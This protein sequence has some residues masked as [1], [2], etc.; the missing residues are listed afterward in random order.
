MNRPYFY[1]IKHRKTGRY[2]VGS[3]YGKN[4]SPE[5]LFTTYFTSSKKIHYLINTEGLDS[6]EIVTLKER[7]DAREY[8]ARYLA[9]VYRLF[10]RDQFLALFF[11]RNLSPGILLDDDIVSRIANT[12]KQRW[13]SGQI[14][15]P[16]P[17]NWKGKPRS[18]KMK[19]RLSESKMG[20][21]V[22]TKT[23][24]KLRK[25]NLGKKQSNATKEKRL[26]SLA[27]N[28]NAFGRKHWLFIS[29]EGVYYYTNGKRNQRLKQLGLSEGPG[30]IKYVNT[31]NSPKQGKNVG[32]LF[33]EGEDR[34]NTILK[35]V[36][37]ER[38]VRY[39]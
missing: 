10:G 11:N 18:A 39:E 22:S 32:W 15:K 5:N 33:Y 31:E 24:Q 1:K 28:K 14:S 16:I 3:Q 6:F 23:R 8:E 19:K 26:A 4:S 38:I 35:S 34:I 36:P 30:F 17:P 25:A 12:R 20:H 21:T 13:E 9:R 27:K 7:D 37:E 2:Y 29:P